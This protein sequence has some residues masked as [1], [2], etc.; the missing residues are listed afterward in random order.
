MIH[1]LR[2]G[3]DGDLYFNQSVY[4]NSVVETPWGVRT[5]NG[6]CIWRLRPETLRL[7][8]HAQ[9]LV[10]PWGHAID[11]W[12]QSFATDGAGG[13]GLA[14]MFPGSAYWSHAYNGRE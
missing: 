9:G 7:D 4:I 14:F 6:S 8:I 10:N 2:W 1:G 13:R 5:S 12:G 3:P 11:P